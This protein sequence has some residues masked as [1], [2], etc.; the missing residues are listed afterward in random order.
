MKQMY[1][2]LRQNENSATGKLN[3]RKSNS[4]TFVDKI[5]TPFFLL[6]E[7]GVGLFYRLLAFLLVFHQ[8]L[9]RLLGSFLMAF[10]DSFARM[11]FRVLIIVAHLVPVA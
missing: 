10:C 2:F 8:V 6:K 9:F 7:F 4:C 3:D 11:R 1:D 5:L